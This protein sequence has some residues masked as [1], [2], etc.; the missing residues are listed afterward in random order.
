MFDE[1]DRKAGR[2]ERSKI[3]KAQFKKNVAHEFGG[4]IEHLMK[5]PTVKSKQE[6]TDD[7]CAGIFEWADNYGLSSSLSTCAITNSDAQDL[8]QC[9]GE[10]LA[11][12]TA[13]LND[14]F[15]AQIDA[16]NTDAE[17]IINHVMKATIEGDSNYDGI[18]DQ[19]KDFMAEVMKDGSKKAGWQEVA[20]TY[21][22]AD[23]YLA[24]Y[25]I[26][27]FV[28]AIIGQYSF[29]CDEV[30][31]AT[32]AELLD[33]NGNGAGETI[34]SNY[35]TN[36]LEMTE[37]AVGGA[38][39]LPGGKSFGEVMIDSRDAGEAKNPVVDLLLIDINSRRQMAINYNKWR[40]GTFRRMARRPQ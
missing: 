3:G 13:G 39:V 24:A 22:V 6:V 23:Q 38:D 1:I 36:I 10:A 31:A 15:C 7:V 37:G 9:A 14:A 27:T 12:G 20:E 11:T 26:I 8:M 29:Y 30:V 32:M 28:A 2:P 4:K 34:T 17:D 18:A 19:V 40:K 21:T 25:G 33:E 16:W 5:A 35:K